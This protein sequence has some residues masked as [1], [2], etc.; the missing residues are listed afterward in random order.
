MA[1]SDNQP[2]FDARS[3]LRTLTTRPGVYRMLDLQ[4]DILYVGKAKNL[5]SRVSSYFRKSGL[6][7][8]TL[9]MMQQMASVEVTVTHTEAEALILENTLI[10]KH[11]PRYNILLRDDK[12]YPYIFLS[13]EEKYP[14][15]SLHRGARRR[16]GRYFGPYPSAGAVRDSLHLLQKTFRVRQCEDSFFS[17]RSRPCLQYQIK[18][19]TAPCVGLIDVDKYAE[20]VRHTVRFLEGGSS[21][22]RDE[23]AEKMDQAARALDYESAAIY[24]D[25]IASLS[26]VQ[27][28][29]YVSGETGD[30]D[31]L[32]CAVNAGSAC[33]QVFFIRQGVNLGNKL[34]F[35]KLPRDSEAEDVLSAFIP[36][37]Y[38]T[39]PVPAHILTSGKVN[40]T[41]LLEQ[42]LGERAGRRVHIVYKVRGERA[43]WLK[44][45]MANAEQALSAHLASRTGVQ[46]RLQL[47]KTALE[48]DELP[49]RMECF[50]ISHTQ[51]EGTVASCVVF[52]REGARKSDYRRFGIRNVQAGDDYAAMEQALMRRYTRLKTEE[53]QL[54]DILFIDGGKGQVAVAQ[55]VLEELQIDEILVVGVSKGP[56]RRPGMEILHLPSQ[57]R[58]LDLDGSSPALHLIQ[59][60]R[61]EAH[62]FAITGHRQQRAKVR[63]TSSLE[64]VPGVG[65]RR[66]Q[67]LLKQFGGLQEVARAGVE[68]LCKVPGISRTLAQQIYDTFHGDT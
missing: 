55:R 39:H 30:L 61:D 50:D 35:P 54:P 68:D 41:I 42:V 58:E 47:L 51:G 40:D 10:K 43:R 24:R 11:L 16:K 53:V 13:S 23:L 56:E 9:V 22:L 60:V 20:D 64:A 38:L 32:A 21:V 4:G 7:P 36:Q 26:R 15:L 59:Q 48:L 27:E 52:D 1:D 33:V 14:R 12:S 46:Q 45:G 28:R 62:R 63:K 18:R 8:K 44:L 17:N 37:Y 66:R 49:R 25:Q 19:C 5:K 57:G 3:F 31:I 65:P 6:P 34:F 29:Q 2:A 67:S